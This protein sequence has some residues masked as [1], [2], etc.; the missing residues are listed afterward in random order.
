MSMIGRGLD[1]HV[2]YQLETQS[3]G[4]CLVAVYT[5]GHFSWDLLLRIAC[6]CIWVFRFQQDVAALSHLPDGFLCTITCPSAPSR[7]CRSCD[8][9]CRD[10][11][12]SCFLHV[13]VVII[14]YRHLYLASLRVYYCCKCYILGTSILYHHLSVVLILCSL[15]R[16]LNPCRTCLISRSGFVCLNDRMWISSYS[17]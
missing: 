8:K 9:N 14:T 15:I 13:A 5:P 16:E 3:P 11:C 1:Q 6:S 2:P 7:H 10:G 17:C 4:K 12:E